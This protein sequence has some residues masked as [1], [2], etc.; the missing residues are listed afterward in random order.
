MTDF[1]PLL[2]AGLAF[3]SVAAVVF[4]VVQYYT[5]RVQAERRLPVLSRQTGSLGQPPTRGIYRLGAKL[6]PE[7]RYGAFRE[8]LRRDLTGAGFFGA[9][10]VNT[11]LLTRALSMSLIPAVVL[12]ATGFFPVGTPLLLSIVLV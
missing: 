10:A 4:V 6:Y 2:F 3:G 12:V 9:D 11:Y 1:V 8:K 5:A 7:H